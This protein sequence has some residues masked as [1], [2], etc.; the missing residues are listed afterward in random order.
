MVKLDYTYISRLSTLSFARKRRS[1]PPPYPH[2][3][4]PIISQHR[5]NIAVFSPPGQRCKTNIILLTMPENKLDLARSSLLECTEITFGLHF[6]EKV[7]YNRLFTSCFWYILMYT[8]SNRSQFS[9]RKDRCQAHN[10]RI[11]R[12]NG[13]TLSGRTDYSENECIEL[14]Q[15]T[16]INL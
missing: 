10:N 1:R 12:H 15:L 4:L 11:R 5:E 6:R 16:T 7:C 9:T 14:N 2:I 8:M 13:T 3:P